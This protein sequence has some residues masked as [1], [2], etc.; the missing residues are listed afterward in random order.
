MAI[1]KLQMF[2]G[3]GFARGS[4]PSHLPSE[5]FSADASSM[6][7][8]IGSHVVDQTSGKDTEHK[9][10]GNQQQAEAFEV[11]ENATRGVF[12]LGDK[13]TFSGRFGNP[14]VGIPKHKL[15]EDINIIQ[16]TSNTC[17]SLLVPVL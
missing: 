7:H 16:Q 13:Q 14:L 5:R 15:F 12:D 3:R 2:A 4:R 11:R 17:V 10:Y 8:K 9:G 1:K 6:D